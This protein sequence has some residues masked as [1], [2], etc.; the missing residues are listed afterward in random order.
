LNSTNNIGLNDLGVNTLYASYLLETSTGPLLPG[1]CQF[2][3][4]VLHNLICD[5]SLNL[6][7]MFGYPR[8]AVGLQCRTA[9][10]IS[11]R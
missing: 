1:E 10:R 11:R 3:P 5:L 9:T 2:Y 4:Q 6:G 7:R 8:A